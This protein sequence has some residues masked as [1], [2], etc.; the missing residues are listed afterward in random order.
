MRRRLTPAFSS[1][2]SPPVQPFLPTYP[3]FPP[4]KHL[5]LPRVVS[6]REWA[7]HG[8]WYHNRL[9]NVPATAAHVLTY[10]ANFFCKKYLCCFPYF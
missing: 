3:F 1:F 9:V 4:I 5:A 10:V 7:R 2:Y 8:S 6:G